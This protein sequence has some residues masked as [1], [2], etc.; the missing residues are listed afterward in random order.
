M[1]YITNSILDNFSHPFFLSSIVF[2]LSGEIENEKDTLDVKLNRRTT[3]Q[4]YSQ[5]TEHDNFIDHS[6]LDRFE[7]D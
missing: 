5:K 6:N 4:L 1:Y 3:R 2:K 7:P